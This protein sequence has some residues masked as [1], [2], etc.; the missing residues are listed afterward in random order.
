MS[1]SFM[2]FFRD[3]FKNLNSEEAF[4][5]GSAIS[6]THCGFALV[7][8]DGN[9]ITVKSKYQFDRHGFTEFMIVDKEGKHYNVN[10]SLWFFKWDSIEDWHSIEEGK[11]LDIKYYGFR[12]P[13]IGTFP[14]IVRINKVNNQ[15]YIKS[16]ITEADIKK[17]YP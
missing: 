16:E 6:I 4:R 9:R 14:N 7:T 8:Q 11:Q 13:F 10:N 2:Y 3:I 1:R 12:I 17:C 15:P 5:I